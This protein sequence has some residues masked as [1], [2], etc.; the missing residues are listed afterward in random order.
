[1]LHNKDA[2]NELR[3]GCSP[4]HLYK[5]ELI[6]WFVGLPLCLSAVLELKSFKDTRF[7]FGL[8]AIE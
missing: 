4:W 2:I 7:S 3:R 6:S 8:N 5:Y 1:M